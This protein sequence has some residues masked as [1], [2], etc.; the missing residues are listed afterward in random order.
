MSDEPLVRLGQGAFETRIYGAEHALEP[1]AAL[2]NVLTEIDSLRECD[3][4]KTQR[5]AQAEQQTQ[6]ARLE[7]ARVRAELDSAR[8]EVA[9][10]RTRAERAKHTIDHQAEIIRGLRAAI[11]ELASQLRDKQETT[12]GPIGGDST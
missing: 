2:R 4:A 6:Q 12:A 8:A 3:A 1:V 5:A 9:E 10:L 7:L 11:C